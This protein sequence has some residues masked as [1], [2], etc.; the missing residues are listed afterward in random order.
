[1]I[2]PTLESPRA[3]PITRGVSVCHREGTIRTLVAVCLLGLSGTAVSGPVGAQQGVPVRS[4]AYQVDRAEQDYLF[5]RGLISDGVYP[6]ALEQVRRF[7]ETYP[8]SRRVEEVRLLEAEVRFLQGAHE[9]AVELFRR[10]EISY[11]QSELL[12]RALYRRGESHYKLTDYDAAAVDF[13]AIEERRPESGLIDRARY[14]LGEA[15]LRL[16]DHD[17]ARQA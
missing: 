13:A 1:V 10:F 12:D 9:T 5:I 7:L 6:I 15:R 16:G 3:R 11:P 2:E 4:D 17:G 14:W 8:E